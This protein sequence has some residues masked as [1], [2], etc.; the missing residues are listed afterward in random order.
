MDSLCKW[1]ILPEVTVNE[2]KG[3]LQVLSPILVR[4]EK[5]PVLLLLILTELNES[6]SALRFRNSI[7]SALFHSQWDGRT[8][9]EEILRDY[10]DLVHR[11]KEIYQ[12]GKVFWD[13]FCQ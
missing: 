5:F 6:G 10:L 11:V 4:K 1:N 8:P 2:I 13:M 7:L 12:K 9:E 3:H